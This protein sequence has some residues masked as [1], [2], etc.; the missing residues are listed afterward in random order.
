M[1]YVY[2][3]VTSGYGLCLDHQ[4]TDGSDGMAYGAMTEQQDNDDADDEQR[5]K[6]VG[7]LV[8]AL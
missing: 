6:D 3:I 8:V 7:Q 2:F 4:L 1:W 5:D